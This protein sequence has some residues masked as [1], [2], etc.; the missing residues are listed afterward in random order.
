MALKNAH[1]NGLNRALGSLDSGDTEPTDIRNMLREMF[2]VKIK[3]SWDVVRLDGLSLM[4][5]GSFPPALVEGTLDSSRSQVGCWILRE[6][7][8]SERKRMFLADRN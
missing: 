6:T 2:G 4:L 8:T 7:L 5:Q 3:A 1:P